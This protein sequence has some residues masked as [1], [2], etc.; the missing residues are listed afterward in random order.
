MSTPEDVA[1]G[2]TARPQM[3]P[4]VPPPVR[5]A[6]LNKRLRMDDQGRRGSDR[7]RHQSPAVAPCRSRV[8]LA[9]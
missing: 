1:D 9:T 5:H 3:V 6:N 2:L 8:T 4:P 7:G